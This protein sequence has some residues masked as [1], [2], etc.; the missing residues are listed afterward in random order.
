MEREEPV[1]SAT[2][3]ASGLRGHAGPVEFVCAG[4]GILS[5]VETGAEAGQGGAA[6]LGIQT[7]RR[8]AAF[9]RAWAEYV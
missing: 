1:T 5:R 8:L 3:P 6:I 4:G 2:L 9:L 7:E